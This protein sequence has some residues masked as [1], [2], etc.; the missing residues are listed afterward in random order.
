[1]IRVTIAGKF[2]GIDDAG[3]E[4]VVAAGA[5]GFSERGAFTFDQSVSSFTFRY[6]GDHDTED[7]AGLAAMAALEAYAVPYRILRFGVTDLREIKVRR[8]AGR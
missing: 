3:R 5:A 1:M 4:R 7:D 8:K 2:E 6:Q